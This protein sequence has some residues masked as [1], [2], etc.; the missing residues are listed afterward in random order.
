MN[1]LLTYPQ[2]E[3]NY[4][5]CIILSG[6]IIPNE[7][8]CDVVHTLCGNKYFYPGND[9]EL[10]ENFFD[11]ICSGITIENLELRK[12]KISDTPFLEEYYLILSKIVLD[13]NELKSIR[14]EIGDPNGNDIIS[15]CKLISPFGLYYAKYFILK[16]S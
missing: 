7:I 8:I 13:L 14:L 1:N 11:D 2:S 3:N 12:Y 4:P 15:F 6:C 16:G 10:T 9:K 5:K